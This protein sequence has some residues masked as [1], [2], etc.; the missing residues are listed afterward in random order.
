MEEKVYMMATARLVMLLVVSVIC[1]PV[2]GIGILFVIAVLWQYYSCK[3]Q[4]TSKGV[5]ITR[6]ILSKNTVDIPF[7]KII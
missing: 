2:F 1:I 4:I 6:G 3:L 5:V 7:E